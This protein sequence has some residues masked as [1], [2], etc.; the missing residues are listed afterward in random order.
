MGRT[1][2]M[3]PTW[4]LCALINDDWTGINDEDFELIAEWQSRSRLVVI[5]PVDYDEYFTKVP[6]FGKPCMVMDCICETY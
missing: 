6:A 2:E 5:S 1:T 4:A 3:I